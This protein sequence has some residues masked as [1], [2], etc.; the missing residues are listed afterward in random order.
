MRHTVCMILLYAVLSAYIAAVNVYG[1]LLVRAQRRK[2]DEGGEKR[3][4]GKIILA[5]LLGGAAGAYCCMLA[6]KYRLENIVFMVL[7][8]V[9][10]VLNIYIFYVAFRSGFA[11][12]AV[13]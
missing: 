5:A 12:F 7:L 8:P 2:R 9:I 13:Q 10:A 6:M 4:D 11:F 3:G 1:A